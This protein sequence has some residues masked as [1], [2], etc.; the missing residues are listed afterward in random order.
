M[1]GEK[2]PSSAIRSLACAS[3]T[4]QYFFLQHRRD[5]S[6]FLSDALINGFILCASFSLCCLN[7]H[8]LFIDILMGF[9]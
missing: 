5:G 2:D 3:V 4:Q 7:T 9:L 1:N 6:P 8:I